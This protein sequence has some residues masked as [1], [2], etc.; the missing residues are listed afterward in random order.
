MFYGLY[1]RTNVLLHRL[2]NLYYPSIILSRK[3]LEL[4]RCIYPLDSPEPLVSIRIATY[5]RANLLKERTIPAILN[6]TYQ[7]FEVIIVGDHCTDN[8]AQVIASFQDQRFKYYES[9][10]KEMAIADPAKRWCVSGYA[11][12]IQALDMCTGDWIATIDDDDE[13]LPHHLEDLLGYARENGLEMV[14]SKVRREMP[15]GSFG[16]IGSDR[17]QCG[18][19]SHA[20]VMYSKRLAFFRYSYEAHK[21]VMPADWEMWERMKRAGAKI[22]FLNKVTAIHYKE[23]QQ[24]DAHQITYS[25]ARKQENFS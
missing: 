3:R 13:W 1:Y 4:N 17:L 12:F 5:N 22:G 6:Q 19:I 9:R 18:E 10:A 14:Y 7:N 21:Y 11:A 8:T 2:I 15:D 16:V 25:T 23:R 20:A 24:D